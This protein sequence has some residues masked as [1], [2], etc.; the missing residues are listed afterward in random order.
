MIKQLFVL[1][2]FVIVTQVELSAQEFRVL[3]SAFVD[4]VPISQ[5]GEAGLENVTVNSDQN[6]I[7][8][9]FIGNYK[10][11]DDAE[12]AK[13]DAVKKGYMNAQIIDMEEQRALCGT[14]CPYI[15]QSS[16][17]ISSS[18]EKIYLRSIQFDYE[19]T[20]IKPEAG[21]ELDHLFDIMSEH[22]DYLVQ[23]IGHT[24]GKNKD[25]IQMAISMRR[26]RTVRNYLISKG[27][28]AHKIKSRV[29]TKQEG[30]V[31]DKKNER[32]VVIALINAKGELMQDMITR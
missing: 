10:S 26:L 7:F 32:L 13:K 23:L 21:K 16:M 19:K 24:E 4:K 30:E 9:Y 1:V 14:P 25:D 3:V 29:I 27:I 6:N 20:V 22:S 15:S 2:L 5:F 17:F 18:T 31:E 11:R 8:R 12:R 28:P